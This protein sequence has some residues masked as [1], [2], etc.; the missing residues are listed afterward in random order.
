MLSNMRKDI[1]P[2]GALISQI[3][4]TAPL[5]ATTGYLSLLAPM[6]TNPAFVD[7]IMFG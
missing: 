1:I 7:P 5:I 6:A 3:F 4:L 2:K